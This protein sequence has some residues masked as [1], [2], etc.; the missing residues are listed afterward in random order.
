MAKKIEIDIV[1][2]GKMQKATVSAKKLRSALDGVDGSTQ[3]TDRSTRTLDRNLK[4][5]AKTTSNSTKEFSKMSQG[6]GGLVGAYATVAASVF[7]L[8]AAFEFLKNAAD[9]AAL[10]R[11]QELLSSSTGVSMKLMTSNIQDATA[12]MV[13]FKEAAQAAAIG[14]AAGLNADQLERL[15]RV[16]KNAGTILGRDVTDSFNRL[17]RGA[18][19]AEPELLD[20]LGIIIRLERATADYADAI[21]KNVKDLTQFEKTQAVVNAVLD[22]GEAKFQDVGDAVNNVTQFGA[23]FRDTFKELSEPIAFVANF[24][25]GAFK[26]N[27]MAVGAVMGILGLNIIKAVAPA[28]PMLMNTAK[29][30]AAAR[31]RLMKAAETQHGSEIAGEVKKGR[32]TKQILKE[33]EIDARKKTGKIINMSKMETQAIL[34][35]LA[36][37]KAQTIRMEAAGKNAFMRMFAS[38]HA[39]LAF[40]VVQYGVA[41]GT[42]K[43]LTMAVMAVINKLIGAIAIAGLIVMVVELGKQFR[44]TFLITEQLKDAE[45]STESLTKKFEKQRDAIVEVNASFVETDNVL[46]NINR[47]MSL[48]SNI[49]LTPLITHTNKFGDAIER[50]SYVEEQRAKMREKAGRDQIANI[51][52]AGELLGGTT[53]QAGRRTRDFQVYMP[54]TAAL[55]EDESFGK[56]AIKTMAD[57]N[58]ETVATSAALR[59]QTKQ[60]IENIDKG[61]SPLQAG[62]ERARIQYEQMN[63]PLAKHAKRL[64][65]I[66]DKSNALAISTTDVGKQNMAYA[67]GLESSIPHLR[68]TLE[69]IGNT[70][71]AT[72]ASEEAINK[73]ADDIANYQA[74]LDGFDVDAAQEAGRK[75]Q[76]SLLEQVKAMQKTQGEAARLGNAYDAITKAALAF[77]EASRNFVPKSS[78]FQG[79]FSALDEI[80]RNLNNI[81]TTFEKV[82]NTQFG[83]LAGEKQPY[84]PDDKEIAAM[85]RAAKLTGDFTDAQF[86]ALTPA[87]LQKRLQIFRNALANEHNIIEDKGLEIQIQRVGQKEKALSFERQALNAQFAAEDAQLKVYQIEAD[88]LVL[89]MSQTAQDDIQKKQT[90]DK[91]R[92]A[93]E[94]YELTLR[95]L[96]L[97]E[98]LKPLREA[99]FNDQMAADLAS[100]NKALNTEFSKQIKLQ[101]DILNMQERRLITEDN[102][103]IKRQE[104]LNPFFDAQRATADATLAREAAFEDA[105]KVLIED[106]FK[107]KVHAINLE[108]ELLRLKSQ[109]AAEEAAVK[110][111]EARNTGD[112][113]GKALAAQYD[114]LAAVHLA[115]GEQ[116]NESE[117]HALVLAKL[118]KDQAMS[119]IDL[120]LQSAELAVT[121]LEPSIQVMKKAGEAFSDGLGDAVNGVIDSLGD[122]TVKAADVLKNAAKGVLGSIR[123]EMTARFIIDPLKAKLSKFFGEEEAKPI[124]KEDI[125]TTYKTIL[126]EAENALKNAK[127]TQTSAIDQASTAM[128]DKLKEAGEF[129]ANLV[130]AAMRGDDA[131]VA[132]RRAQAMNN[133]N[134]N[135]AVL[136]EDYVKPEVENANNVEAQATAAASTKLASCVAA[137][138]ALNVNVISTPEGTTATRVSSGRGHG[139]TAN[140]PKESTT[141]ADDI[142]EGSQAGSTILKEGLTTAGNQVANVISSNFEWSGRQ[143]V[144]SLVSS[145]AGS[146]F[147]SFLGAVFPGMGAGLTGRYGGVFESYGGGGIARGREAGYPAMLHGTEAVVPLPNNRAIPVD[148]NGAGSQQNNV[149]V[150]VNME[151]GTSSVQNQGADQQGAELGSVVAAAVQA[152]L[153][154]QKRSGG[155]LNPYGVS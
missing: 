62:I 122:S 71:L 60:M 102:L 55:R 7:A 42:L 33:I 106:E 139:A 46:T 109:I 50:L 45:E 57:L 20:E 4:G 91:L 5:A 54:Q 94:E 129:H 113:K 134:A 147:N 121:A 40:F 3:S 82:A 145:L 69:L 133:L 1:V 32:F 2:N 115:M 15:G 52:D 16:A 41:M 125:E 105:K 44:K 75:L 111:T 120:R 116:Y 123:D 77:G 153:Q 18:I 103:R 48:L 8:S 79:F 112:V 101:Q 150:N 98:R 88:L 31:K 19:K 104:T 68:K 81:N 49:N 107:K 78:N 95:Q 83:T 67:K 34:A 100:A 24:I 117:K 135:Q 73:L 13:A 22:Q 86:D 142:K 136:P 64:E 65:I 58:E 128:L 17:T 74:L 72:D 61:L 149:T 118:T 11:G 37:I 66:A 119:E 30:G 12:G 110:A 70:G 96:M 38:W 90:E 138:S 43:A 93:K 27:I 114:K 152:E 84:G 63:S 29:E 154:N 85:K 124:T 59:A 148:L 35:D 127:D 97:E 9:M 6:M 14:Q 76:E 144:A 92:L 151:G 141:V 155:I 137:N 130:A 39:Q 143:V 140:K 10:I 108:Y 36:Q 80:D 25:A 99:I 21:N 26:D 23:A 132:D 47:S 53:A 89:K 51:G 56:R 146:A 28:G 131:T 87:E 126:A